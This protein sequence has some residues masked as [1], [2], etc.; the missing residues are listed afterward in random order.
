MPNANRFRR[1]GK[2]DANLD[3][4]GCQ[5]SS[6]SWLLNEAVSFTK[7][8]WRCIGGFLIVFSILQQSHWLATQ[9]CGQR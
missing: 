6:W 8:F 2:R 4:R 9:L 3:F 7:R 1:Q 5:T